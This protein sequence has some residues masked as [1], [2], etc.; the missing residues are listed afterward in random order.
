M[1]QYQDLY[2]L[3]PSIKPQMLLVA[4]DLSGHWEPSGE[5]LKFRAVKMIQ[6]ETRGRIPT[7]F[8]QAVPE[9]SL[10]ILQGCSNTVEALP[11]MA[12][13]QLLLNTLCDQDN[14]IVSKFF[15]SEGFMI[16]T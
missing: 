5:W 9:A 12:L 13:S 3:K 16:L 7:P 2:H 1:Q 15:D 8:P 10:E 14:S 4:L 11:T 6:L